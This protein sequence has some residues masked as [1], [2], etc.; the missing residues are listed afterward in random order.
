[1]LSKKQIAVT[2]AIIWQDDKVLI[3][4]RP[5]GTHLEGLWE[6]PGG[7][8]EGVETLEACIER[9]IKEELGVEIR[10]EKYLLSVSHEYETKL[11]DLH[12]F[13]CSLVNG[14]PTPMEGQDMKWVRP[15]DMLDY[16]FPPPDMEVIE[17]IRRQEKSFN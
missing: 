10:V 13:E 7:K 15:C 12:V 2:A 5:E 17:L 16:N 11:V 4:R 3:T 6:F 8:K 9:E 14:F 1:M